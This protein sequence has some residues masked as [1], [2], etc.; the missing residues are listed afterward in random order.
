MKVLSL[1]CTKCGAPLEVPRRTRYF[2][3]SFCNSRLEIRS[4]GNAVYTELLESVH[5]RTEQIA[6]DIEILRLEAELNRLDN[7]WINQK[8][9]YLIRGQHGTLRVP[10]HLGAVVSAV[11]ALVGG[12]LWMSFASASSFTRMCRAR[13]I[14]REY[15]SLFSS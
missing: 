8:D 4:H 13:T 15:F 3:C 5:E 2:T 14:G 6:D 12:T 7:Q 9:R 1:T 11:V 10:S